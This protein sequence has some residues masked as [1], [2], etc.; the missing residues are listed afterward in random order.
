[1]L[2]PPLALELVAVLS[3]PGLMPGGA[4]GTRWNAALAVLSRPA[5]ASASV[6][7]RFAAG[8]AVWAYQPNEGL[9]VTVRLGSCDFDFFS[10]VCLPKKLAR[11]LPGPILLTPRDDAAPPRSAATAQRGTGWWQRL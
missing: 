2:L 5:T 4:T 10:L 8:R 6:D 3:Q 11:G 9:D 7:D 1:V